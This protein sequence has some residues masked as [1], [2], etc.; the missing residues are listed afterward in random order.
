[1]LEAVELEPGGAVLVLVLEAALMEERETPPRRLWLLL[2]LLLLVEVPTALASAPSVLPHR[3]ENT[4]G[5]CTASPTPKPRE[6][7]VAEVANVAEPRVSLVALPP[8]TGLL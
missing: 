4:A 2:L 8:A 1:M 5:T 3:E 7:E 6:R